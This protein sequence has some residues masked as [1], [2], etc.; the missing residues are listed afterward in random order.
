MT[1]LDK[2]MLCCNALGQFAQGFPL[3]F[4]QEMVLEMLSTSESTALRSSG[5]ASWCLM[6][7]QGCLHLVLAGLSV[8]ATVCFASN[9]RW[10]LHLIFFVYNGSALVYHYRMFV[11]TANRAP[12]WF[13]EEGTFWFNVV[14]IVV[15]TVFNAIGIFALRSSHTETK[16]RNE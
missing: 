15:S 3:L 11:H 9:E 16:T 2:V 5:F 14:S 10:C 6:G 8:L 7:H 13:A 4:Q 12:D 1:V